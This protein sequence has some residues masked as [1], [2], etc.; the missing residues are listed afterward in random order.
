MAT[1][2]NSYQDLHDL[3]QSNGRYGNV[4]PVIEALHQLNPMMEDAVFAECSA[5]LEHERVLRVGLPETE[6]GRLYQG[7]KYTKSSKQKV[8]DATGFIEQLSGIDDRELKDLK[9]ENAARVR[10]DEA[11]AHLEAIAQFGQTALIYGNVASNPNGIQGLAPRYGR[12]PVIGESGPADNVIDG[13]GAGADNTSIWFVTWGQ[14]QTT[15]IYPKGTTMGVEREDMG[16]TPDKDENG[17][18]YWLETERFRQ[19]LGL[20]IGD[21]RYNARIANLDVSDMRAGTVDVIKLM[22]QAYYRMQNRRNKNIRAGGMLSPGK[23]VIYMNKEVKTA[24][25]LD[26]G[27][28]RTGDNFIRLRQGEQEGEEMMSFLGIPIRE[29]DGILNSEARVV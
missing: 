11:E 28:K 7:S 22:I 9:S 6:F 14:Q 16:K 26:S 20:S 29:C 2:G 18:T 3:Y 24:L 5:G 21:W 19:H 15:L 25:H 13:G 17:G 27:N 4:L 12:L 10:M 8:K 1:I 23:T